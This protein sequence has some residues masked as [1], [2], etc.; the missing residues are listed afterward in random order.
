M[1]DFENP[2]AP[3]SDD[4]DVKKK[5]TNGKKWTIGLGVVGILV[6]IYLYSKSKSSS[7]SSSASTTAPNAAGISST[8]AAEQSGASAQAQLDQQMLQNAM[9]TS[10]VLGTSPGYTTSGGAPSSGYNINPGGQ[11]VSSGSG[12]GSSTGTTPSTTSTTPP[13][14]VSEYMFSAPGTNNGVTTTISGSAP[15]LQGSGYNASTSPNY[16]ALANQSQYQ[17]AVARHAQID[18]QPSLGTFLPSYGHQLAPNTTLFAV[19]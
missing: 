1:S 17:M 7:S 15:V 6:M 12:G 8:M 11:M 18:Y 19:T 2:L 5:L 9:S 13:T 4:G 3:K 14:S 10:S 16:L